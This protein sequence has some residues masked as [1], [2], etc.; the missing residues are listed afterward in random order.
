MST[1]LHRRVLAPLAAVAVAFS[2]LLLSACSTA[3][4]PPQPA[5]AQPV[6]RPRALPVLTPHPLGPSVPGPTALWTPVPWADVPGFEQDELGAAWP[7]WMHS[8]ARPAPAWRVVCSEVA[9]LQ[10]ADDAT[11]RDW[12]RRSL[13]PYLVRTLEGKDL[14][15]L[16]AYYEPVMRARRLRGGGFEVPLYRLPSG[17]SGQGVWFSRAQIDSGHP[18]A[19]SALSGKEIAWLENPVDAMV[20]HIQGSGRLILQEP[21]GD[22]RHLRAAFAGTNNHPYKSIGRWLLERRLIKDASWPGIKAW[23]DANP[24]ERVQEMLWSNPRYVFFREETLPAQDLHVGPRGAQGVPLTPG[25]SIA[26]DRRSIPYGTPVW[27]MTA[28]PTLNTKRLVLA[29]DTGSAITGAVR[30][31]YF[32]GWGEEA[33]QLAGR[34]KQDLYM[35]AF[36]PKGAPL[37]YGAQ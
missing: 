37:P 36:W 5:P 24:P 8:C 31:D 21:N 29:Q 30:A 25:R 11:R 23:V 12:M 2:A 20:L 26:V 35:W 14:G 9:G 1:P 33:G 10:T 6:V 17:Y 32:A 28:G 34:V 19:A 27:L 3:P 16:T 4:E 7:A 15:L 22:I 18:G 13:Q